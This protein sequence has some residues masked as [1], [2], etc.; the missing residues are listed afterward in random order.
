MKQVS[1]ISCSSNA[2]LYG[3]GVFTTIAIVR[4]EPLFWDRH[5]A[6]LQANANATGIS[7]PG[8]EA[9]LAALRSRLAESSLSDGRAR[10]TLYENSAAGIWPGSSERETAVGIVVGPRRSLPVSLRIGRSQFNV[11]SS[12][13]LAGIKSCNYLENLLV[14]ADARNNGFDEAIRLNERGEVTAGA[15]ANIFWIKGGRVFTPSLETGCLAGTT[16]GFIV[17]NFDVEE[18]RA[19]IDAVASA[20]AI[21]LTSAGIGA[22]RAEFEGVRNGSDELADDLIDAVNRHFGP[23]PK[24]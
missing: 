15:C 14:L 19:E 23:A 17:D 18:V 6:R 5:V 9:L 24:S 3:T 12:S 7:M 8:N 16:R 10:I 22:R 13:P 21:V 4:G 11:N 20:D 2:A 1:E